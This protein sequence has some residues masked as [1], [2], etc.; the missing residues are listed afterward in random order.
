MEI[1]LEREGIVLKDIQK[2]PRKRAIDQ[3]E[4]SRSAATA[5]TEDPTYRFRKYSEDEVI[6]ATRQTA[7]QKIW[8]SNSLQGREV[9]A[10]LRLI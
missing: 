9:R 5:E 4:G 3:A 10:K 2:V 7:M 6:L 1:G 8:S